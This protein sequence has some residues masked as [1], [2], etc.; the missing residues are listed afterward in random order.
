MGIDSYLARLKRAKQTV[1]ERIEAEIPRAKELLEKSV[2]ASA[3]ITTK[4]AGTISEGCSN[5]TV[6]AKEFIESEE[7]KVA[8][9]KI[10][11]AGQRANHLL[12]DT[13]TK[14]LGYLRKPTSASNNSAEF[15]EAE[16]DTRLA[17]DKLSALD[18]VGVTGEGLATLGGAAAGVAAAG[19][20][21]GVA[22]ATTL[23]GS[24]T[25]A[26]V[27]GG[28]FLTTTP[29]GWV[30]G[31]AVLAGAAG[32]GIAKMVRS[33]S[34]Q[35][36][37]RREVIQRLTGR[38]AALQTDAITTDTKAELNQLLALVVGTEAI[39]EEAA[40]RMVGL[41]E[42][43]SLRPEL[44]LERIKAIAVAKEVIEVL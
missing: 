16:R 10:K 28:L 3:A 24:T 2:S 15:P 36:Q 20:I 19:T 22:G 37:V 35:D 44:A 27:F 12:A 38:L 6:R 39:T 42:N 34:E 30:I 11:D 33:G 8:S 9:T 14:A 40:V 23:L 43:G 4:A 1:Q 26:S 17:I 29:V 25:L 18:K 31:S 21:A 32:Y 5:A 41:V 13:G 7:V